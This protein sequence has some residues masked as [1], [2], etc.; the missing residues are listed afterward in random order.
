M[1]RLRRQ[2]VS[3]ADDREADGFDSDTAGDREEELN[4]VATDSTLLCD[5]GRECGGDGDS[6]SV[7]RHATDSRQ[8]LHGGV[9]NDTFEGTL[10]DA[11]T[12]QTLQG[13]GVQNGRGSPCQRGS[14]TKGGVSVSH[15]MSGYS[16]EDSPTLEGWDEDDLEL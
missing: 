14:H 8:N 2:C 9:T 7:G 5:G 15:D 10:S 16:V 11:G 6:P 4:T 13:G 12:P 3:G 1:N